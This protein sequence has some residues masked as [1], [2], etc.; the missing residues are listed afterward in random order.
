MLLMP[1]G[2]S[3]SH[4]ALDLH[5]PPRGDSALGTALHLEGRPRAMERG[6]AAAETGTSSAVPSAAAADNSWGLVVMPSSRP[7]PLA[8]DA[9]A[10]A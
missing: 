6:A 7:L 8:L 5:T 3:R 10:A 9:L 2:I 1:R 4:L